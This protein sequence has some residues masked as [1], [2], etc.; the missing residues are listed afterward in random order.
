MLIVLA[1]FVHDK[2]ERKGFF[3]I[4]MGKGR[5]FLPVQFW[6]V[7]G[8]ERHLAILC[9][10]FAIRERVTMAVCD[11]WHRDGKEGLSTAGILARNI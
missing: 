7:I 4:R 6:V 5:L 10:L 2:S 9:H 3:G 8:A 11:F 1:I